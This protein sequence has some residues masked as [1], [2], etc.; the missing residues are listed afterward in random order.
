MILVGHKA[1]CHRRNNGP[2]IHPQNLLICY[3]AWQKDAIKVKQIDSPL[4]PLE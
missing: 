3:L 1:T 4:E 2:Q